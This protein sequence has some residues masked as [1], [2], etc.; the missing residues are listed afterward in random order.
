MWLVLA[1]LA[2]AV[3]GTTNVPGPVIVGVFT[4]VADNP[5]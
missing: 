3:A 2:G 4:N 1:S 5:F